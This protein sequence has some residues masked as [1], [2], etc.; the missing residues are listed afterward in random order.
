MLIANF[1]LKNEENKRKVH[2]YIIIIFEFRSS[3]IRSMSSIHYFVHSPCQ[4]DSGSISSVFRRACI[5]GTSWSASQLERRRH[6][7]IHGC[8]KHLL[9]SSCLFMTGLMHLSHLEKLSRC[10]TR[11]LSI[12]SSIIRPQH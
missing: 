11:Q 5:Q 3:V 8:L 2:I 10:R 1:R 6:L 9:L 4:H 12:N 7:V